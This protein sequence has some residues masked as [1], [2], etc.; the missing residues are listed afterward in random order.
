MRNLI[1]I[2]FT[3]VFSFFVLSLNAQPAPAPV[4]REAIAVTGAKIHV[5]DGKFIEN[6]ILIFEN[7]KFVYVGEDA[8]KI[9]GIARVID[10][11]GS[12]VYPGFISMACN[13]GLAEIEQVKATLDYR[14]LGNYNTNIRSLT[15]YNT[16]SKVIPTVRSNGVLMAQVAPQGG[17]ISGQSS[18]FQLDAWNWEDAVYA[19]DEGI[20]LN[21]PNPGAVGRRNAPDANA[22]SSYQKETH[23]L[24]QYF[25]T[26]KAYAHELN[27][28]EKHLAYDAMRDLWRNKKTLYI[29]VSQPK[30]MIHAVLF[31]KEF[32]L[33]PVLVGA[34]GAQHVL[35]F[36][37]EHKVRIV[38]AQT[39]RLPVYTDDAVD[40]PFR[41]PA[42]LQEA[43]ILF[44]L[45][46]DGFWEQRNLAFQAG[47]CL[48]YGLKYEAAV[49]SISSNPAKILGIDKTCGTLETGK[50][51]TFVI[52]NGDAF[53]MRSQNITHAFI[54][55]RELNLD[56]RQKELYRRFGGKP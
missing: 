15:S 10:V 56:D 13:L 38:L 37:K 45:S 19:A 39:H 34:Q 32:G 53:D 35:S 40:S 55:G 2:S 27:P 8:G 42:I 44:C 33:D 9:K 3:L 54:Q 29:R 43:G 47:H 48:G 36:L 31:A 26:A 18:V 17:V 14:E 41:L 5:G 7:S 52:S 49:A 16:D 20:F 46:M 24:R 21:W 25:Q 28:S 22:E 4:Q 11:K 12:H 6:G 51:A 1:Y 50:D 23:Q 30:A